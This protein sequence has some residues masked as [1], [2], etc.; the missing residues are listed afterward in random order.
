[1]AWPGPWARTSLIDREVEA[2]EG[3]CH[4]CVGVCV[5]ANKSMQRG[6][7]VVPD[8]RASRARLWS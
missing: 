3:Y 4:S 2:F 5:K 6:W 8:D 7:R 1:M